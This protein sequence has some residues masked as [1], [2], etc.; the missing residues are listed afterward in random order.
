MGRSHTSQG[1][2]P[3]LLA[4]AGDWDC[5]R[6]AVANGADAVYFGLD[7]GFNAR[8]RATNFSLQNLPELMAFLHRH[9]VAGYVTTNIL[10][11]SDELES[12]E[13]TIRRIAEAGADAVLVQD[14][15]LIHL[16]R[17]VAPELSIH[18]STQMTLTCAESIN[19]VQQLGVERV[20][21]AR[22]LSVAEIAKIHR[23]TSMQLEVFVHGALCV[24]YSGQCLTSE[25]L[26]GRSA[27]RGQCAQA[28]RLPY[29]LICDDQ[30]VELGDR[31]YLL[32]PRDLAAYALVPELMEAGA[33]AL[34]IEGRLKT[35]E[36]V[37][38]ITRHYR[39]AIDTA[40]AG[41]PI[42]FTPRQ[43]EEM[44][45]SFSR[46]FSVGWLHGCDHKAL[47]SATSSA[48]RGILIGEIH[49]VQ[50]GRVYV[51]LSGRLKAGDGIVFEGDRAAGE[52]Q[53]G[54]IYALYQRGR[55]VTEEIDS[56]V[57][58]VTL[59]RHPLDPQRLWAGQKVW[60]SD[61]PALT[62]RLR[63]SFAGD[64]AGREGA[65]RDVPVEILATARVGEPLRLVVRSADEIEFS[66]TSDEPL[67][68]A[69][70][71][72]LTC[73][74]LQQQL[75]RL[76]GTGFTLAHLTAT[77]EGAP[78]VPHSVLGQLRRVIVER[79]KALAPRPRL[80]GVSWP[81]RRYFPS[82]ARRFSGLP[83]RLPSRS[84]PCSVARS[85][86]C[87]RCSNMVC[88][89]CMPISRTFASIAK[90]WT[91]L[92]CIDPRSVWRRRASRN[93]VKQASFARWLDVNR[94]PS[95]CAI[96]LDSNSSRGIR[97]RASPIT[98]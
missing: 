71:H 14:L 77:I 57:V 11:F 19:I 42:E 37:A 84:Y 17:R 38:N 24:A 65:G 28:C 10:A 43:V 78:M 35:P 59:H 69:V 2:A 92:E 64:M 48:K 40:L 1:L 32:S 80:P 75:G 91:W 60:K 76:G 61:D 25:S 87:A 58:E 15:G 96:W 46:G 85:G 52:E 34:K 33:V 55:R 8:A 98:R 6:A 90:R 9:R 81:M 7:T 13:A 21:L 56:G 50:A 94:T 63:K 86:S 36:Y 54:R 74:T 62:R 89:A 49:D 18:A 83:V 97:S 44:E 16:I 12:L 31:K 29:E 93:R 26:G 20:V 5:I 67:S 47:V 45:L 72:P 88:L 73:E 41:R 53:G 39:Q 79:L 70:K 22:E 4:P 23:H 27:N 3:E 82:C 66:C 51:K 30:T 95:W 68:A